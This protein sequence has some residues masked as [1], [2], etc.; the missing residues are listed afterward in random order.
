MVKWSYT[1]KTIKLSHHSKRVKVPQLRWALGPIRK[2][3]DHK[4]TRWFTTKWKYNHFT[5]KTKVYQQGGETT[6]LPT[7]PRCTN[8][9]GGQPFLSTRRSN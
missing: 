4:S 8:K 7:R 3:Q 6:L 9:V 5:H 2:T 1:I